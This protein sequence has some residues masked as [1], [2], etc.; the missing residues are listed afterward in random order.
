ME[1]LNGEFDDSSP[2]ERSVHFGGEICDSSCFRDLMNV[3]IYS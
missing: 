1:H 2:V 3:V